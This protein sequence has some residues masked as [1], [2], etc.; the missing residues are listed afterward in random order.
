MTWLDDISW[1][2]VI[3]AEERMA[4]RSRGH[5]RRSPVSVHRR[6][7]G[8]KEEDMSQRENMMLA[9]LAMPVDDVVRIMVASGIAMDTVESTWAPSA[10]A[11][12]ALAM[13]LANEVT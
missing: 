1:P 9:L 2:V 3:A 4:A 11:Y 8:C 7:G 13:L 5:V 12:G 6:S 10:A